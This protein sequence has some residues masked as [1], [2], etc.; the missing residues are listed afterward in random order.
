MAIGD[1]PPYYPFPQSLTDLQISPYSQAVLNAHAQL[2][3]AQLAQQ[4]I[5]GS[6]PSTLNPMPP[7]GI[8]HGAAAGQLYGSYAISNEDIVAI[9]NGDRSLGLKRIRDFVDG[10]RVTPTFPSPPV[11]IAALIWANRD[12]K[13][14]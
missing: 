7:V 4:A 9:G 10:S 1:P 8:G 2:M 3:Q 11:D 12:E 6:F 13:V 14:E 5:M